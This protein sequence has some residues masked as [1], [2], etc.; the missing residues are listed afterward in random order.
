MKKLSN[1]DT[2]DTRRPGH[3]LN[4]LCSFNLRPASTG[5]ADLKKALLIKKACAFGV[6]KFSV[7]PFLITAF[8]RDKYVSRNFCYN[9]RKNLTRKG[10][11]V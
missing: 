8:L 2:A 7:F 9:F 10:F 1:T 4:V 11:I 6:A 3:L 5:E